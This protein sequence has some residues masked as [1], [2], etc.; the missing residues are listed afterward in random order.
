MT[1]ITAKLT[2]N[3]Y[4]NLTFFIK[5]VHLFPDEKSGVG[6]SHDRLKLG[7]VVREVLN[8]RILAGVLR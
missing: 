7:Q 1:L 6:F 2:F 3:Q 5:S 8:V 4:K